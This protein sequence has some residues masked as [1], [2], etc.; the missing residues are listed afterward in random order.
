[1]KTLLQISFVIFT[2]GYLNIFPQ[3]FG[4]VILQDKEPRKIFM[5]SH[6]PN[7]KSF[8]EKSFYK[9]K[10]DWQYIIDTTWGPGL[11]LAQK[12]QIFNTF[13]T[14]ISNSFDGF[15]SLGMNWASWDSLKNFYY[16]KIDATTSRGRFCAIMQYLC[17][18][19][20]DGHTWCDDLEVWNTPLN[21]GVP[22]LIMSGNLRIAEH[23]GAVTTVLPDSSVM[24][25]RVV[26][27][28]PLNLEPGD[29]ILGYEGVPWKELIVELMEA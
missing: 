26:N 21:P 22:F 23:L 19:L 28:H 20:R 16:S 7:L 18:E 27:N 1:M 3:E 5:N 2:F 17:S 29:I 9:Q 24:I 12:Q 8:P 15:Q 4:D 13:T 14:S 11:P 25:L 6:D 10:A